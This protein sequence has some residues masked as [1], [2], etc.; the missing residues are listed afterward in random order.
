MKIKNMRRMIA[1]LFVVFAMAGCTSVRVASDIEARQ[2]APVAEKMPRSK[3]IFLYQSRVA[4]EIFDRYPSLDSLE[5]ADPSL[6]QAEAQ[7]MESCSALS[8][9]VLGH[10]D[11]EEPSL[12]LRWRVMTSIDDCE[13]AARRTD[14]LLNDGMIADAI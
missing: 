4:N 12:N 13:A 8:Q 7:M 11:G 1:P 5:G 6:L 2:V 10:F 14:G 3:R 9:A